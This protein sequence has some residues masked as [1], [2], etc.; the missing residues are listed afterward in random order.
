MKNTIKPTQQPTAGCGGKK[1]TKCGT[2]V[3]F[4]PSDIVPER[5]TQKSDSSNGSTE[6]KFIR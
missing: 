5:P 1:G 3:Y 6:K 4:L 2:Q